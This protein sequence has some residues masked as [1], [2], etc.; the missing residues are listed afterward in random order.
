VGYRAIIEEIKSYLGNR[1]DAV[2]VL[3]CY[4]G[5]R[6]EEIENDFLGEFPEIKEK[7]FIDEYG[8]T[9]EE[10]QKKI[11]DHITED[12]VFGVYSHYNI[13]DFYPPEQL[14]AARERLAGKGLKV[15]Y[16]FGAS[17][18][19]KADVLISIGVSRWE[20]QLRYRNEQMTNWKTNNPDEE[21]IGKFK[22]GFFFEWPMADRLQHG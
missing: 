11:R 18:L 20:I 10:V 5:V 2:I 21:G 3:E 4:P 1:E 8:L 15:I 22:R 16:G 9:V 14:E 13:Q 12:R 17:L 19:T 7:I 6:K